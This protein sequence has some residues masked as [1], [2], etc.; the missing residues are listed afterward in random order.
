MGQALANSLPTRPRFAWD[1][2]SPPWT[3]LKGNQERFEVAV[4]DWQEYHDSFLD[5]NPSKLFSSIQAL[6]LI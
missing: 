3:D 2:K 6:V 5:A 1:A 4:Q